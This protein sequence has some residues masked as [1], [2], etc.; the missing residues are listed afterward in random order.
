[1]GLRELLWNYC[2]VS[3]DLADA[4]PCVKGIIEG[5]IFLS[6]GLAARAR[7]ELKEEGGQTLFFIDL[8][9]ELGVP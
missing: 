8:A 9:C 7:K 1:V 5:G 2:S 6:P 4:P 3:C